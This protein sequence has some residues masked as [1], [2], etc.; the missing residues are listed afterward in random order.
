MQ[1]NSD[2]LIISIINVK[3]LKEVEIEFSMTE[4]DYEMGPKFETFFLGAKNI[5]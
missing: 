4:K 1:I 3:S 2:I 5:C